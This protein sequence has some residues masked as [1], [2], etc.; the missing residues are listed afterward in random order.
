MTTSDDERLAS[1]FAELR[2]RMADAHAPR[3]SM[4]PAFYTSPDLAEVE[5]ER[6]FRQDWVCL[7]HVAEIPA[8]GDYFTFD[9]VDEPLL[10]V[11]GEDGEVR[12]LSNVCRHRGN[13]VAEGAGNRLRFVCGYH[14]WA[15]ATDGVLAAAPLMATV[16]GFDRGA[17][18]LPRFRSEIWQDF[19]FVDLDGVSAPLGPRLD[20]L[21]PH[22]Q[23]YHHPGR[24]HQ[25]VA[26]ELW[27]TNWKSLVENFIEGYHLSVAHRTTL[28]PVTPTA[29]CRRIACGPGVGAYLAGYDP[30]VPERGPYHPDLTAE[31]RRASV[32]FGAFPNLLVGVV[33]NVTL[34]MIISPLAADRVSVKWGLAG[35]VD[36]PNDPAVVRYRDLCFAFNA[37]DRA[38]LEAVQKGMM[39]RHYHGGPLAPPDFEG[40]IWDFYG[41]LAGRLMEG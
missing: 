30:A 33:P 20:G 5:R 4:P 35:T 3:R 16:P 25:F 31:E 38:A 39:S 27:N 23:N 1:I 13:L 28:H 40:T 22:I 7:G 15:Y 34:Y 19:I 10:V 21:L 9:L 36:D 6:I 17:C 37:E 12:V 41:Y 2:A 14:G 26:Q 11:R 24:S 29:L 18:A 8:P 32:M